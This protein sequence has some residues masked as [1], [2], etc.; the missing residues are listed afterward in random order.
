MLAS[1]PGLATGLSLEGHQEAC[2][3]VRVVFAELEVGHR[4][5]RD[6]AL[7]VEQ[8]RRRVPGPHA[9]ADSVEARADGV[10]VAIQHV[11]AP[12]FEL[13]EECLA[14]L[15]LARRRSS[16]EGRVGEA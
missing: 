3:R 16:G 5:A 7:G 8:Q 12:A 2:D 9:A 15:D 1:R 11:T 14:A 4:R 10:A 13:V 6:Y